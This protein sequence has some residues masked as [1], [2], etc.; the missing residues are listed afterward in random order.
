MQYIIDYLKEKGADEAI[1]F[2][3]GELIYAEWAIM[4][5]KYGCPMYGHNRC[6]PPF[7]ADIE[8]MRRIAADYRTGVLF[9]VDSMDKGTPLAVDAVKELFRK[10]FYKAI[11]FGT[12]PCRQ[13]AECTPEAC[14]HPWT[15]APSMEACGI[16]V[17]ATAGA[18]G[19]DMQAF[20]TTGEAPVCVGMILID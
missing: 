9:T 1:A 3:P 8:K 20:K 17:L 14:P 15:T 19:I 13:C 11:G 4:K 18:Q 6:C 5:C 10:G 7:A 2:N 12:G 16:D